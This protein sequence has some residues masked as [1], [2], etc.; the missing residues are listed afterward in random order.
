MQSRGGRRQAFQPFLVWCI[1]GVRSV[2]L[3]YQGNC[4]TKL[5]L[6]LKS[7]PLL[8]I[9]LTSV[10]FSM[11]ILT[12]VYFSAVNLT[13]CHKCLDTPDIQILLYAMLCDCFCSA[14]RCQVLDIMDACQSAPRS[15]LK[16]NG[17][18]YGKML[19]NAI[20]NVFDTRSHH[21]VCVDE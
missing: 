1:L 18:S 21:L 15:T 3:G 6:P 8:L 2:C 16:D 12:R 13:L 9:I 7:L 10:Y 5:N 11:V 4:D 20:S 14:A 17:P 19:C